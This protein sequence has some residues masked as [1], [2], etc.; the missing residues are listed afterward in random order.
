V[1]PVRKDEVAFC[2]LLVLVLFALVSYHDFGIVIQRLVDRLGGLLAGVFDWAVHL[3]Q[4]LGD[5]FR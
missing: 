1:R 5:A 3:V 4:K 2:L